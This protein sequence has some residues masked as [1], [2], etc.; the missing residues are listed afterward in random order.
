MISSL[1]QNLTPAGNAN[2]S[3]LEYLSHHHHQFVAT[4]QV[5]DVS[6][7]VSSS[8][9]MESPQDDIQLPTS[10]S[11]LLDSQVVSND[12]KRSSNSSLLLTAGSSRLAI[13]PSSSSSNS[14]S[15]SSASPSAAVSQHSIIKT[16]INESIAEGQQP[17]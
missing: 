1:V 11:P 16:A 4:L 14:N 13:T 17:P 2:P 9:S 7:H 10:S 6:M 12:K 15:G 8:S 5:L 3:A